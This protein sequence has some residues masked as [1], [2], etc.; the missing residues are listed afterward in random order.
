MLWT[1]INIPV[2]LCLEISFHTGWKSISAAIMN[3]TGMQLAG[4][5]KGREV[6]V[7]DLTIRLCRILPM[8]G[9]KLMVLL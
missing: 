2:N 6:P 9:Q 8:A 1:R 4:R 3:N 7:E 5:L